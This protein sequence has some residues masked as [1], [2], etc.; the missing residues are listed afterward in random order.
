MKTWSLYNREEKL[1]I[2]D[3]S[4][5]QVKIILLSIST[6]RMHEWYACL[7]GDLSWRPL[8][9]VPEYFNEVRSIQQDTA[10]LQKVAGQDFSSG[11][12]TRVAGRTKT[13]TKTKKTKPRLKAV[14]SPKPDASGEIDGGMIQ[15][16]HDLVVDKSQT[17]ERRSARRY[18]RKISFQVTKEQNSFNSETLDIS[19]NGLSLREPLPAWVP[20]AFSATLKLNQY[21][22][23]IQCEKVSDRKLK[24]T[25][26]ESWDLIRQWIVNW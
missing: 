9:E 4:L 12:Q 23:N 7:A 11:R 18:A 15:T 20:R 21:S 2:D 13:Q 17:K 25:A 1:R 26:A 6:R 3:L 10:S 16:V 5:E 22:I 19:M 14:P 8:A 24:I